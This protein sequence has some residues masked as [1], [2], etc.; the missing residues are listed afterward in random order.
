MTQPTS[1]P[2]PCIRYRSIKRK[3][4][5]STRPVLFPAQN[6]SLPPYPGRGPNI[7]SDSRENFLLMR[8][9]R[10]LRRRE[11]AWV[12]ARRGISGRRRLRWRQIG[13]L[14]KKQEYTAASRPPLRQPSELQRR[15]WLRTAGRR[16]HRCRCG[17]LP[18]ST[19]PPRWPSSRRRDTHPPSYHLL[20]LAC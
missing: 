12:E 1:V 15:W 19:H 6:T 17:L 5:V 13:E 9:V 16:R 20:F 8:R 2:P 14:V 10:V 7:E 18:S 3:S 4:F 11:A